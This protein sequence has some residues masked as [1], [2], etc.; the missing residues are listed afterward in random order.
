MGYAKRLMEEQ[1]ARGWFLVDDEKSVCVSEPA[2]HA[3]I[4][5]D[6][7]Q[8]GCSYCG[9]S[10]DEAIAIP[11]N[12]LFSAITDGIRSEWTSPENELP[13]DGGEYVFN[14]SIVSSDELLH[15][16]DIGLD[17]DDLV[18][19]FIESVSDLAWVRRDFFALPYDEALGVGWAAFVEE[20]TTRSRYLFLSSEDAHGG[21]ISVGEVL[22]HL[23]S[24]INS[25]EL[26]TYIPDGTHLY[27]AR[28]HSIDKPGLGAKALGAPPP[29]EARTSNRM[30]PAGIAMF[31]GAFDIDCVVVF[32]VNDDAI[33]RAEVTDGDEHLLILERQETVTPPRPPTP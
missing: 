22:E 31:Y 18:D 30:S 23:G 17:Q 10:S 4:E 19:D 6:A 24:A 32:A 25:A 15:E 1:E 26:I 16:L 20:V 11:V 14:E 3:L 8:L 9:R 7:R 29:E 21:D 27:R 33:D 12:D 28:P 13:S 5:R 2:L